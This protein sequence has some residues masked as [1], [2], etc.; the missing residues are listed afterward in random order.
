MYEKVI[1]YDFNNNIV[2]ED[3]SSGSPNRLTT[4]IENVA[5]NKSTP[6]SQSSY[7]NYTQSVRSNADVYSR[8]IRDRDIHINSN[9][10]ALANLPNFNNTQKYSHSS[11]VGKQFSQFFL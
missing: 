1:E 5:P 9:H 4:D 11:M 3:D 8:F 6:G 10:S 7:A 2:N